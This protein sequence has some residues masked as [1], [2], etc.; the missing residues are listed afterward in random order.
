M[1]LC[2][3]S[4]WK[5]LLKGRYF[6]LR[7]LGSSTIAEAI[8]SLIAILMMEILSIPL[9]SILQVVTISFSIK[10]IYSVLLAGPANL[11]V[12]YLK[13]LTGIDV[14]DFPTQFTPFKYA[15]TNSEILV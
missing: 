8:Y 9:K 6:W 4:R 1:S 14:Y 10:A 11:L 2:I 13:K 3:L 15:K 12:N 7:S 5:V